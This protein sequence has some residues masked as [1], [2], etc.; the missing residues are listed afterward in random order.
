MTGTERLLEMVEDQEDMALKQTVDY[1]ISRKDMEARY[2]NQEKN[3]KEMCDF[4]RSKA[5]SHAKNGWNYI[6]DAVVYA[7][8]IMYFSLPNKFLKI[9]TK[10]KSNKASKHS[11]SK[12]N[13]VV[14][15]EDA[16]QK[17]EQKK[18]VEQLNLFGGV[19]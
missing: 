14:S 19:S 11:T 5:N 17:I 12:K 2:L 4:I 6:T 13:N 18:E 1:L 3:L 16:K 10:E 9:E 7:W 8:A 15:I